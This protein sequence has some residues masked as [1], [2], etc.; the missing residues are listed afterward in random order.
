MSRSVIEIVS[1]RVKPGISDEA[2]LKPNEPVEA[3]LRAQSGFVGR[4][5]SKNDDGQ[6]FDHVEWASLEQAH[7]AAQKSPPSH[8]S[9]SWAG[10]SRWKR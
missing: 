2:F 5:L 10:P 3:F 4:H 8:L 9:R 7:A 6:W 1:F